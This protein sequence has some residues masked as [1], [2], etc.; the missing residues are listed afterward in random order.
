VGLHPET[1]KPITAGL[2]RYGPFVLHD[3]KYAN[4]DSFEEIFEVGLNRA[5]D[6]LA[7]K[8]SRGRRQGAGALRDLGGHP[9]GGGNVQVMSGRYGPYVKYGKVNATL[10]RSLTPET[11]TL[12]EAVALIAEKEA[13]GPAAK[14][15]APAKKAS[16]AKKSPAKKA[17]R[18]ASAG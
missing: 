7:S 4:L 6:A 8:Q 16:A 18:K 5:V 17:A 2:G 1:G 3:G 15:R 14:K 12:D 13:K 11:I 9:A 10:P